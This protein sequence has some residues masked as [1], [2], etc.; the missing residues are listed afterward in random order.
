MPLLNERRDVDDEAGAHVGIQAGINDL[1][2]PMRLRACLRSL[3]A[4]EESKP[5]SPVRRR[6][7]GRDAAPANKE[8]SPR[9]A[10]AGAEHPHDLETDSPVCFRSLRRARLSACAPAHA[11]QRAASSASCVRSS[12]VP[13]V[14]ASP[15][16][17]S[18]MAVRSPRAPMRSSVPAACLFHIVAMR[19]NREHIGA[20]FVRRSHLAPCSLDHVEARLA[21]HRPLHR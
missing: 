11:Q 10:A 3:S 8:E 7:R 15:L 4:P 13:R 1:E 17:R 6:S 21:P 18:R 5:H 12:A 2:R 20:K 9:E 16:V 19:G 14:P